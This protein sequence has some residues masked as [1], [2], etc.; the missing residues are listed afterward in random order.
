[1]IK[2]P[3][4]FQEDAARHSLGSNFPKWELKFNLIILTSFILFIIGIFAPLLTFEKFFI[5]SNKVSI[6]SL[7]SLVLPFL[8]IVVLCRVWNGDRNNLTKHERLITWIARY[9][10]WSMLDVFVAAVLIVTVKLG[11]IASVHLRYG[12]YAFAASVLLTMF[13]TSKILSLSH[14][15]PKRN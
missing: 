14:P 13:A 9:G 8:K 2:G 15:E 3:N 7:F 12:L 11:A 6:V 4:Q 1:M 10:K 5:F